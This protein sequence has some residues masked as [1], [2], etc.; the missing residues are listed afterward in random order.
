MSTEGKKQTV[1]VVDDT[2]I[3]IQILCEM[4]GDDYDISF[5]TSGIEALEMIGKEKPDLVLLDVM[6]P[7]M[8]GH[9]VCK[10]LKADPLLKEIPVIFIT[11]LSQ[12]EDEIN[13]LR[14]GAVDYISKPFHPDIVRLRVHNQLE[15][16]RYRD[17]YARLSLM[18]GLTGIANR[19]AFD[20]QLQRE[21]LRTQRAQTELSLVMIDIDYFKQFNDSYGH[22][23]GDACLR[24]VATAMLKSLRASDFAA[25]YGGEEFVCILPETDSDGAL[26][27]AER[28]RSKV[29]SLKI[30]HATSTAS[31]Y[32]TVSLGVVTF[33]PEQGDGA[34]DL[35]EMADQ[36]LYQAKNSGRNR[37][38]QKK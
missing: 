16:K 31:G 38:A 5:A 18:D 24:Q 15:L 27:T 13:G 33:R 1:L 14:A 12:Q 35:V 7:D 32:V 22:L 28:I 10:R 19:R 25:R 8:N 17:I 36:M 6:M 20:E 30:I 23:E 2:P 34:L 3:N 29:E 9:E 4:L 21:W 37:V 26:I 11:A